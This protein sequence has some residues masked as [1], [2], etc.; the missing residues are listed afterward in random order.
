MAFIKYEPNELEHVPKVP[1][2]VWK[3]RL[4][5][6][7]ENYGLKKQDFVD[8]YRGM[9]VARYFDVKGYELFFEGKIPGYFHSAAGQEAVAFGAIKAIRNDDYVVSNYRGHAHLIA[10]GGDVNRMMAEILG[11]KTGL[12]K[13]KGGS[14]YVID[15]SKGFLYSSGL[16]SAIIP[17]ATGA[18][19]AIKLAKE[20][21]VVLSFFGDG[22]A[23]E[24]EFHECLNLASVWKLPIVFIV[25]N[26]KY[27]ITVNVKRSTSVANI[28]FR[29]SGYGMPGYV[30][31]GRDFLDVYLATKEAVKRAR[32]GGGPSLIEA[33]TY[34][35]H[36]H[37]R[38]DPA[39]GVYRSKDVLEWYKANDPI[40]WME[41]FL[42]KMGWIS[43]SDVA[44]FRR[45]A[46]DAVER[47]VK[48]A[49]ESPYPD[50]DEAYTDVYA[51]YAVSRGR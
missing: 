2:E 4:Q 15:T 18:G 48:T 1:S 5:D 37:T 28:A 16:V 41:R 25:E 49:L 8:I 40:E 3:T 19:L 26:N 45:E 17:V 33:L 7:F 6:S 32:E 36:G 27:S 31:D 50:K 13:G 39:F 30:V 47:A 10:K 11:K 9:L 22:A 46:Q 42:L 38:W 14:M 35:F 21:K 44:Q 34:R 12:S 43:Q 29:A 51:D 20:D 24:G 23:N